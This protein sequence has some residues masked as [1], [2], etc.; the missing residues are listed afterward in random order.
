MKTMAAVNIR[1][2]DRA[3]EALAGYERSVKLGLRALVRTSRGTPAPE[4]RAAP[5]PVGAVVFGSDQ[6][7]C[8]Q[9]NDR[10]VDHTAHDLD[11]RSAKD[12]TVA[13]VGVRV[14]T[15]LEEAGIAPESH[16]PVPASPWEISPAVADLLTRIEQW[17]ETRRIDRVLLY[18]SRRGSGASYTPT[19][20]PLLPVD[21]DRLEEWSED[22]WP[23]RSIPLVTMNPRQLFSALIRHYLFA[24]LYRAFAESAASENASRL[25]SMQGAERNVQ[26]RIDDLEA[27]YRLRRQM[28][29]TEELLDIA[30]GAE[31]LFRDGSRT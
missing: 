21:A 26:E 2:F 29:I 27:R 17:H 7:M 23:S 4:Q 30:S 13:A 12:P 24:F 10:I 31:A 3:V 28:S 15:R 19:T 5:G 16:L 18:Y 14:A 25:A 8:G 11:R 1:H 22:A 20:V 6:G 9:L